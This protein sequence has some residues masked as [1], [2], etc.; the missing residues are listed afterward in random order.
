MEG[1]IATL[2]GMYLLITLPPV[3][4]AW[5]RCLGR[6]AVRAALISGVLLG[7]TVIGLIWAWLTALETRDASISIT[8]R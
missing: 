3:V 2:I 6:R 4:V 7:W 8:L 5:R 1:F